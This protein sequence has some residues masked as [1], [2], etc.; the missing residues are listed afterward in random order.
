M[1]SGLVWD[2]QPQLHDPLLV[3]AFEGWNDAG[4]AAS[5]AA[6]WLVQKSQ[7][8]RFASIDPD[9]HIDY[10][11]RR[12]RVELVDGV[13]RA[14]N[15][16]AHDY[17]AAS[18]G[19]RDLV[20]LRGVEPNIR[21]KDY[22]SSVMTV[23]TQTGCTMVV[24]LGALLGDVPHTRRVRVTGTATDP[25]LVG[26][27]GL[28]PSRYEGPTGIVG[29]LND[30]CRAA[31]IQSVSLWA[32]VPHYIATPPNPP[33]TRAL[34]E[35][36]S[37]LAGLTLELDGLEQLVDIW[38]AQVDH[39]IA[40]NDEVQTYVRRLEAQIDAEDA[41]EQGVILGGDDDGDDDLSNVGEL[42]DEVEKYLREQ[43]ED[44]NRFLEW[45]TGSRFSGTAA[46]VTTA[47]RVVT[48]VFFITVSTGKFV[49]HMKEAIDFDRYG[50][51]AAEVAVYLVGVIELVGG[52]LLVV[53]L[54]TRLAAL[55][56]AFN[57]VGAIATAGRVDGGSF[58]LGVAPTLLV[59]MLFLLWAG[60]GAFAV[61]RNSTAAVRGPRSDAERRQPSRR[62]CATASHSCVD[63][64]SDSWSTRS[65]LPWNMVP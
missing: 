39:A 27:L 42:V 13:T 28:V 65:S 12:P 2:H 50:V 41:S 38:R 30:A 31:G 29:V 46:Y 20:V 4:D 36:L 22:C 7:A 44:V 11:S 23:A 3:A 58:H 24:T 14:V 17:Y 25:E 62:S 56:L 26:T 6:D 47:I 64:A 37:T 55:I 43:G 60:S 63:S 40:D 45:I 54:F 61:D 51:P 57:M 48:G 59:A 18:F 49:D 21:W 16:P 34:L 8:E 35:R 52:L 10:Q 5:A 53:G 33:A 9:E 19:D 1:G 32:P 15:W